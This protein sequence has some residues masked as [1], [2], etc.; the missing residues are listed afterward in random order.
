PVVFCHHR[1][2]AAKASSANV[3]SAEDFLPRT[4][5]LQDRL[6]YRAARHFPAVS[7]RAT[8][9]ALEREQVQ[10]L[11]FHYLVDARFF[12]EVKR[13]SGLPAVVEA[14]GYDVSL[15]PRRLAGLGRLYLR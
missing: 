7:A 2:P 12:L 10:L 9:E 15:F 13:L 6:S 14:H 11:H 5:R 8:V 3:H 1:L 4:A